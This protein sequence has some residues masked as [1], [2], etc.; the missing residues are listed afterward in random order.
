[1]KTTIIFLPLLFSTMVGAEVCTVGIRDLN[2]NVY[3]TFV[4]SSYSMNAACDSAFWD[5]QQML[6]D[7][8]SLGNHYNSHCEILSTT[9]TPLFPPAYPIPSYPPMYPNYPIHPS[10]PNPNWPTVPYYPPH[11]GR[12][13]H[14]H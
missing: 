7:Y 5:C 1:M 14:L 8:Q 10:F 4:R 12:W 3:N 2:G 9:P 13:P 11:W 6:S